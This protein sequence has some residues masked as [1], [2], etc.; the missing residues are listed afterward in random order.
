MVQHVPAHVGECLGL[1]LTGGAVVVAG[2]RLRLRVDHG[3]DRVEHRR[4]VEPALELAAPVAVP[5]EEQL[6]DLR[7][8][9]VVRLLT[10][11]IQCVDQPCAPGVQLARGV[12]VGLRGELLLRAR[13]LLRGQPPGRLA[14][15]HAGD[16]VDVPQACPSV[17]E[18][19]GRRGQSRRQWRAV[20]P[21]SR[22]DVLGGGDA[23]AGLE[24]LQPQQVAQRAGCRLVAAL[25][26]RATPLQGGHRVDR[27]LVQ[28]P[29]RALAHG[30]KRHQLVVCPRLRHGAQRVDRLR[31]QAVRGV[32]RPGGHAP[33]LLEHPFENGPFDLP[34]RPLTD[35]A[36]RVRQRGSEQRKRVKIMGFL[37]P[38]ASGVR[39]TRAS[40]QRSGSR[41]APWRA[42]RST[43]GP[44]SPACAR[45]AGRLVANSATMSGTRRLFVPN[46]T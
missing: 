38:A 45:M 3:G 30:Q 39:G 37:G 15:E 2:Q 7:R 12:L 22:R 44:G 35:C 1:P 20:Q 24:P 32:E 9:P 17:A 23:T 13:P 25:A 18:D 43:Q 19:R 27:D 8:R 42:I 26:E 41:S 16:D 29:R 4:V 14:A 10:V 21:D 28:P 33:I 34:R 11:L 31:E 40:S 36:E 46:T 6:V 5:A